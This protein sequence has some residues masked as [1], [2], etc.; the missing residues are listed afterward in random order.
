MTLLEDLEELAAWLS[1]PAPAHETAS[2]DYAA[3]L[4]EHAKRLRVVL[5]NADANVK[6]AMDSGDRDIESMSRGCRA[7]A[8][9]L[10]NG[11]VTK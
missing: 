11:P 6:A 5:A 8:E 7:M 1:L 3:R 9:H 10:N 2:T 4:R